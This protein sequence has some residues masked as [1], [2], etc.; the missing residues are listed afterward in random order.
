MSKK[1]MTTEKRL[2]VRLYLSLLVYTVV[3]YG[4]TLILDYIFSK[5]DNGDRKSVV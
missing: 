3:G 4:L 2:K 1:E 5:F